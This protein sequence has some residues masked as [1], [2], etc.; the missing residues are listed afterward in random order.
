MVFKGTT[1]AN[2]RICQ[3]HLQMNNR[4]RDDTKLYQIIRAEG[5]Q[6]LASVPDAELI[7]TL[8]QS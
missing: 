4:E 8:Q 5:D 2:K 1:R 7:I 3:L 6:F